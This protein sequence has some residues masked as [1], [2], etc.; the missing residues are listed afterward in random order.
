MKIQ[1][2]LVK[3]NK[4]EKIGDVESLLVKTLSLTRPKRR[5]SRGGGREQRPLKERS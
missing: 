3:E 4:G 5:I 1:D 2:A